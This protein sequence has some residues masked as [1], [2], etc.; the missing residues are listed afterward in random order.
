MLTEYTFCSLAYPELYLAGL[1]CINKH[2]TCIKKRAE[3][4]Q[5]GLIHILFNSP[6]N[7]LGF[8]SYL[9]NNKQQAVVTLKRK[10]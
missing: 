5:P 3:N 4:I 7:E 8:I 6:E 1:F 2:A 9:G 10:P